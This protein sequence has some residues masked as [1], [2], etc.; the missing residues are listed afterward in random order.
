MAKSRRAKKK[1]KEIN[2]KMGFIWRAKQGLNKIWILKDQ[3]GLI[4]GEPD[5]RMRE[6]E[7]RKGKKREEP[8]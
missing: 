7:K 8:R 2:P 6:E 1:I 3:I 4:W 5:R